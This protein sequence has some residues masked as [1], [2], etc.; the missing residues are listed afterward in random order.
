MRK[1]KVFITATQ[2]DLDGE[3]IGKE[4]VLKIKESISKY[5]IPLNTN[6]NH[7]AYPNGRIIDSYIEEINGITVLNGIAEFWDKRENFNKISKRKK[8]KVS[9]IKNDLE[10]EC[11]KSFEVGHNKLLLQK[12]VSNLEKYSPK[13]KYHFSKAVS[14]DTVLMISG[15]YILG[16]AMLTSIGKKMGNDLYDLTKNSLKTMYS[17]IKYESGPSNNFLIFKQNYLHK[18]ILREISLI[19]NRPNAE[20]IE[21]IYQK[22]IS[23]LDSLI[24][25]QFEKYPNIAILVLKW[26]KGNIRKHYH[27]NFFCIPSK[28]EVVPDEAISEGK[29]SIEG[30]AERRPSE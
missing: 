10:I 20:D 17:E 24:R 30:T 16:T 5:Y 22:S 29:T 28:W 27:L 7:L 23:Q 25:N 1:R 18:N 13:V 12:M 9:I 26:E 4:E 3:I 8:L 11:S 15:L 2:E 6:H 14:F 21:N 19:V